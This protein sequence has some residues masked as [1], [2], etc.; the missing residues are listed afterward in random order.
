[1]SQEV[2]AYPIHLLNSADWHKFSSF[3]LIRKS[4]ACFILP[5]S[6][7][8]NKIL[9]FQPKGIN[10]V[11]K[12]D[13]TGYKG[14]EVVQLLCGQCFCDCY[15]LKWSIG[16]RLF[17]SGFTTTFCWINEIDILYLSDY[18]IIHSIFPVIWYCKVS[19]FCRFS[20]GYYYFAPLSNKNF[21]FWGMTLMFHVLD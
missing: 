8:L 13:F 17:S 5:F 18:Q 1:M 12:R 21:S 14:F 11:L 3:M 16:H 15:K 19:V 7:S 4:T 6:S 9:S 2:F 10:R 20:K